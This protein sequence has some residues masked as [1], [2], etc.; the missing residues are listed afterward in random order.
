[1][2]ELTFSI[3]K[4]IS[5]AVVG[6]N[7]GRVPAL[8]SFYYKIFFKSVPD[9]L[10]VNGM[11]MKMNKGDRLVSYDIIVH[12][13]HEKCETEV[14]KREVKKSM[15]VIDGGANI[16]YYTLLFA[17]KVGPSGKVYAFEP[18][19]INFS[20]LQENV[21]MNGFNN[22][23]LVRKALSD[24][25][26]KA[27]LFLSEHNKGAH[28][29]FN[30]NKQKNYIMVETISLDEYFKKT[31]PKIDFI[32]LDTEGAEGKILLGMKELLKRNKKLKMATEFSVIGLTSSG[33]DPKKFLKTL[34]DEGFK[35]FRI[36]EKNQVTKPI[37][38]IND[39][40]KIINSKGEYNNLFC[41]RAQ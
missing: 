10:E 29:L 9:I 8:K 5:K 27:K 35:I 11:K 17:K 30:F 2:S 31:K 7:F 28:S 32:K 38:V 39:M 33:I 18:D 13:V 16:G 25:T 40:E 1:M 21:R 26:G 19:P 12:G 23:V 6:K 36:D 14:V 34:I 41:I 24:S 22:V 3:I 4:K 15:T 20:I 37:D